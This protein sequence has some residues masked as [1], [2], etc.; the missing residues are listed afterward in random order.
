MKKI[1]IGIITSIVIIGCGSSGGGN[2][3][4]SS[5]PSF[6]NYKTMVDIENST[7]KMTITISGDVGDI[8]LNMPLINLSDKYSSDGVLLLDRNNNQFNVRGCSISND[9]RFTY[10]CVDVTSG[11]YVDAYVINIDDNNNITGFHSTRNSSNAPFVGNDTI[12]GVLLKNKV[13][14]K[15]AYDMD[16][17]IIEEVNNI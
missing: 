16:G 2:S 4:N 14:N 6:N 12:L 1:L 8:D 3:S 5:Q 13:S 11:G 17:D 10:A 15:K 7:L 9:A